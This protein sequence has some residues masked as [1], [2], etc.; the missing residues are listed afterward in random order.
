MKT[1]ILFPLLAASALF[2][3][4]IT[5]PAQPGQPIGGT[6]GGGGTTGGRIQYPIAAP[7]VDP[8][9]GM[10]MSGAAS[11]TEPWKD[12]EWKDPAKTLKEV[13][14]DG[15]PI[16]EVVRDL[17]NQFTNAFDVLLPHDW[18]ANP[19]EESR[20]WLYTT[21]HLRLNNVTAS[22]I[23]NAMNLTFENNRTPLR[24]SLK[25]NGNRHLALLRVVQPPR[26]DFGGER[27]PVRR[28]IFVGDLMG[29]GKAA[30]MT[31]DQIISTVSGVY[32]MSFKRPMEGVQFHKDAQLLIVTGTNEQLDLVTQTLA[33]L[34]QKVGLDRLHAQHSAPKLPE[35]KAAPE[36][37]KPEGQK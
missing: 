11:G 6:S 20:D 2:L 22:E 32:Q 7:P 25:M 14:Y 30:D 5:A 13:N 4:S 23:F 9:T 34:K 1:K 3:S 29:E 12:P 8:D 27:H 37:I 33:G 35:V 19:G 26:M 21:I 18:E 24:W 17:A 28:V 15:L 10:P 36:Y 31:M 16:S